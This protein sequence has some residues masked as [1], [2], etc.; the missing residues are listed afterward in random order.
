MKG[1]P[2]RSANNSATTTRLAHPYNQS[3]GDYDDDDDDDGDGDGDGY[4]DLDGDKQ[5][6]LIY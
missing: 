3:A 1:Q 6:L 2:P 5:N 4:G